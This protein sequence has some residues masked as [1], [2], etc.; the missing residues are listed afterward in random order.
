MKR[1]F[2]RSDLSD[3][4]ARF[5]TCGNLFVGEG[6]AVTGLFKIV[7]LYSELKT[8]RKEENI[9]L[10]KPDEDKTFMYENKGYSVIGNILKKKS[11]E[12][13]LSRRFIK[14][15][16][17]KWALTPVVISF[18]CKLILSEL[19]TYI[20]ND[21]TLKG[22]CDRYL[23]CKCTNWQELMPI[24]ADFLITRHADMHKDYQM[25]GRIINELAGINLLDGD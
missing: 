11:N 12:R 16:S 7:G 13:G 18:N 15:L 4:E 8:S 9:S 19:L 1:F 17:R 2:L 3:R 6:N 10:Y 23:K 24:Q 20:N 22:V 21:I 5:Y 25:A 14:S